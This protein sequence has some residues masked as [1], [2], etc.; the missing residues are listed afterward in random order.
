MWVPSH[1][2]L[3][4]GLG[5]QTGSSFSESPPFAP[6]T[7]LLELPLLPCTLCRPMY[8]AFDKLFLEELQ[9]P[10]LDVG[11]WLVFPSMG[12]HSHS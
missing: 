8:D 3:G 7:L 5:D 1:L 9:L 10:E 4:S 11:D 6:C 2:P 12:T